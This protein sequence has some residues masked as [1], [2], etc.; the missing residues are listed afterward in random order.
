MIFW[1]AALMLAAAMLAAA[2]LHHYLDR[3]R[4]MHPKYQQVPPFPQMMTSA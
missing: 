2:M 4:L 3:Q 1:S